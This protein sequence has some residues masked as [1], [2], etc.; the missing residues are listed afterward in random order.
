MTRKVFCTG[1]DA[2]SLY[3]ES[4]RWST[5][6]RD[7]RAKKGDPSGGAELAFYRWTLPS[8]HPFHEAQSS[9]CWHLAEER[10]IIRC[11]LDPWL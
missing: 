11:E 5:P 10:V 3:R 4:S 8:W 7:E 1:T 6:V 9:W 2:D